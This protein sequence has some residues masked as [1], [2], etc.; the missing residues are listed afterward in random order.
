MTNQS[1]E[2]DTVIEISLSHHHKEIVTQSWPGSQTSQSQAQEM[3]SS[4]AMIISS[5]ALKP[6]NHKLKR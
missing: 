1:S 3:M 2:T 6:A 5:H 4:H